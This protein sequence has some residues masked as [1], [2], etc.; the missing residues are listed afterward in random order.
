MRFSVII[1][2]YNVEKY[3]SKCLDSVLAQNFDDFEII[4]VNDGSIDGS[5]EILCQYEK[6]TDKLKVISQENKG[7]GGARNTGINKAVGDYLIFLDGDDYIEKNMFNELDNCLLEHNVDILVFDGFR[8]TEDGTPI[9]TITFPDYKTKYTD[10]SNKQ[11]QLLDAAVWSKTFKR[12]LFVENK[13]R[14]PENLWYEDF[15]TVFRVSLFTEK[16]GYLKKPF[17]NYVQQSESITHSSNI[18]KASEIM[19]SFDIYVEGF[20]E[21]GS[22]DRYYD[23]LEWNCILH[24]LYYSAYR[25]LTKGYYIK[26]MKEL[27]N[28]SKKIFPNLE[29]N[30]YIFEKMDK[31][32]KMNLIVNHHYFLFYIKTGLFIKITDFAKKLFHKN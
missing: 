28:Y 31:Y 18:A 5:A 23:E 32:D 13:I 7:P 20:K 26:E 17:Y 22:F 21:T 10:I 11:F 6:K 9:G 16:I 8:V 25:L 27:Y 12:T 2:V 30:K 3:I 14:F 29:K 1:P 19:K 24:V 15:A 4:A